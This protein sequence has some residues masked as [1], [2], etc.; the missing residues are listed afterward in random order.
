MHSIISRSTESTIIYL[1]MY[2]R[3][4][5]SQSKL[6][7]GNAMSAIQCLCQ[8]SNRRQS[9]KSQVHTLE[10]IFRMY[11]QL[12]NTQRS[13]QSIVGSIMKC[14]MNYNKNDKVISLYMTQYT[15]KYPQ[16]DELNTL[17]VKACINSRNY[18]KCKALVDVTT[19]SMIHNHSIQYITTLMNYYGA[20][21]DVKSASNIFNNIQNTHKNIVAIN[22]MLKC[23]MNNKLYNDSI[24]LYEQHPSG[25]D[26]H[27]KLDDISHNLYIKSCVHMTQYEKVKTWIQ[28]HMTQHKNI[29][30]A[31]VQLL[32]TLIDFYGKCGDDNA[33]K[34]LF[35]NIPMHKKDIVSVGAMMNCL[36]TNHQSDKAISVYEQYAATVTH[37]DVS[38]MLFIKACANH[39]C[40]EKAK[41]MI[42]GKMRPVNRHSIEFMNHL[43]EFYGKTGDINAA[44]KL[45]QSISDKTKDVVSINCMMKGLI[46]NNQNKRAITLYERYRDKRNHIT[47]NLYIKAC[48]K[49]GEHKRCQQMMHMVYS[50]VLR[51]GHYNHDIELVNHLIDYFGTIGDI[52]RIQNLFCKIADT[53]KDTVTVNCMMKA[54]INSNKHKEAMALYRKF[55]SLIDDVSHLLFIKMCIAMEDFELCTPL[56]R[57]MTQEIQHHTVEVITILMDF[58]GKTGDVASATKIFNQIPNAKRDIVCVGSM[59][60]CCVDHRDDDKAISLYEEYKHVLGHNDITNTLYIKACMNVGDY[61]TCQATIDRINSDIRHHSIQYMTTLISFYGAVGDITAA[62]NILYQIENISNSVSPVPLNAMMNVYMDNNQNH[63]AIA[64]YRDNTNAC[65]DT[66]NVLFIK[67]CINIGDYDQ[68]KPICDAMIDDIHSRDTQLVTTLLCFYGKLGEM[69]KALRIFNNTNE[70]KRSVIQCNAML[71]VFVENAHYEEC[72][73]LFDIMNEKDAISYSIAL[74]CCGNTMSLHQGSLIVSELNQLENESI[75]RSRHVQSAMISMFGKCSQFQKAIDIFNGIEKDNI[76][77]DML[78]VF[79]AMMDCYAKMGD[80]ERVLSLFNELKCSTQVEMNSLIYTIVLNACSH[81]GSVDDAICIFDQLKQKHDHVHPLCINAMIDCL[82]RSQSVHHWNTAEDIYRTYCDANR[83]IYYKFR[84]QALLSL[85]SSCRTRGDARRARRISDMMEVIGQQYTIDTHMRE[86]MNTLLNN[87][88]AQY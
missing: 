12:D 46:H 5:S 66:S 67:A 3:L 28:T 57:E 82:A 41:Q 20:I 78:C 26:I 19:V 64:I 76:N 84:L 4:I 45:F 47:H 24:R 38:N 9:H 31:S 69:D 23:F 2:T 53:D 77:S 59:M 13:N 68:C 87:I 70:K 51:I 73:Q 27:I 74:Q 52:E 61:E 30:N 35:D 56:V 15:Q 11:N 10:S 48:T 29:S 55:T 43:I 40:T 34:R 37:N 50:K 79:A 88:C 62:R 25:H 58:Y 63:Q 16:N 39:G 33:A 8:Q 80:I 14:L 85:L 54:Y 86:S 18:S 1:S 81:S 44:M 71:N 60:K 21:G 83:N 65:D 22:V 72:L 6:S 17:F 42:D 7:N 32:N 75:M 36:I 49:A